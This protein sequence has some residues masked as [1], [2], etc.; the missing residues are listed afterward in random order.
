M[1]CAA[2][3]RSAERGDK[4]YQPAKAGT[5]LDLDELKKAVAAAADAAVDDQR[6]CEAMARFDGDGDG[7][8]DED[9]FEAALNVLTD[10]KGLDELLLSRSADALEK[11]RIPEHLLNN[12]L[13]LASTGSSTTGSGGS[14]RWTCR[15]LVYD[16]TTGKVCTLSI[17]GADNNIHSFSQSKPA[18]R[19]D[20]PRNVIES[21]YN[22]VSQAARCLLPKGPPFSLLQESVLQEG[23]K[24]VIEVAEKSGRFE[25]VR[26]EF[27]QAQWSKLWDIDVVKKMALKAFT[28]Q[29]KS[30]T[31]LPQPPL[32]A[33]V[34]VKMRQWPDFAFDA[35]W[36]WKDLYPWRTDDGE[37]QLD[38]L[39]C[40]KFRLAWFSKGVGTLDVPLGTDTRTEAEV[41]AAMART[42]QEAVRQGTVP[43]SVVDKKP[44]RLCEP[45]RLQIEVYTRN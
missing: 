27:D 40:R 21:K 14:T 36:T 25:S 28:E 3:I 6:V 29:A 15:Y 22:H 32:E 38:G 41:L 20:Y 2:S 33:K 44:V 5:L 35:Y 24:Q 43:Q 45:A 9:E 10:Y 18:D 39:L 37:P 11:Q 17:G 12:G 1:G 13:L 34:S 30:N 8:L 31:A 23:A 42:R 26:L 19:S 16:K 4:T 7:V